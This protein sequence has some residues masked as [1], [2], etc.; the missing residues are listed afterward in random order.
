MSGESDAFV[1]I[2]EY[3]CA[4]CRRLFET[5]PFKYKILLSEWAVEFLKASVG[6][7]C[8]KNG[9]PEHL[10]QPLYRNRPILLIHNTSTWP[11]VAYWTISKHVSRLP[12]YGLVA[13]E[14]FCK[15]PIKSACYI[16]A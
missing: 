9:E 2:S 16:V 13:G 12:A 7:S 11:N 6:E 5:C 10:T 4:R 1:P 8:Y 15:N 14:T 3:F